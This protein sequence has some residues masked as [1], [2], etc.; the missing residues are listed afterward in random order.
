MHKSQL[1]ID[2]FHTELSKSGLSIATCY[3]I[4]CKNAW[5]LLV[6]LVSAVVMKLERIVM[7][8]LNRKPFS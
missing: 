8:V 4:R 6:Q 5:F 1:T 3:C 7:E 2:D